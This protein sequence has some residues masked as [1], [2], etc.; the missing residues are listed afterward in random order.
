[1][2]LFVEYRQ[3]GTETLSPEVLLCLWH[4]TT[5]QHHPSV[6]Q[7][8]ICFESC[9]CSHTGIEVAD[10]ACCLASHSIST[11]GRPVLALFQQRQA[12]G[13]LTY[14]GMASLSRDSHQDTRGN[15][16]PHQSQYTDTGPTLER[17]AP[18]RAVPRQA[19]F[20][21]LVGIQTGKRGAGTRCPPISS[22]P[23]SPQG[24][25]DVITL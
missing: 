10:Q 3:W 11:P 15:F 7:G 21:S 18:G 23:P 14:L 20:K 1:M 2:L 22:R 13:T 16:L 12:A 4:L 5:S 24:R 9:T 6:S 19:V 17:Q 25:G 8:Q